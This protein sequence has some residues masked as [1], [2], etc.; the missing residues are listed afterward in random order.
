MG[1]PRG[2]PIL[3]RRNY[4]FRPTRKTIDAPAVVARPVFLH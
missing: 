3:D 1:V 2:T 4:Y